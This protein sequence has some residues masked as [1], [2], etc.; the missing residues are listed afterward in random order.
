MADHDLEFVI[1]HRVPIREQVYERVSKLIF[2]GRIPTSKRIVEAK[3]AEQLG[4][5]RTPVREALHVPEMEG[6]LEAIPR[7]G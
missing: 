5:S 1:E 7:I 2:T 4:V 6:F 3:L